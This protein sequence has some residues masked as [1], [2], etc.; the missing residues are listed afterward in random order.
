MKEDAMF[1]QL[2]EE[3]AMFYQP[4]E[5]ASQYYETEEVAQGEDDEVE[6]VEV[7]DDDGHVQAVAPEP[8][9]GQRRR[10]E[11]APAVPIVGPPF[12]GGPQ[13]YLVPFICFRIDEF[14][15]GCK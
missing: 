4:G 12:L 10:D 3:D 7:E 15:I 6:D 8:E 2:G 11:V 1:Y 9:P 14:E 13:N 5:E